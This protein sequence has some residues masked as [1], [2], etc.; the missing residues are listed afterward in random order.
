ML[1]RLAHTDADLLP[2][3]LQL[4]QFEFADPILETKVEELATLPANWRHD[5]D[6]TR[7]IG[8]QW[9][10]QGSSCLLAVP[11]AILPEETNYMLNPEHPCAQQLRLVRQRPFAFDPRLI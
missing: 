10:R 11:S 8:R 6:A 5:T 1:E 3:D 9:R 7:Q 2:N 4:A